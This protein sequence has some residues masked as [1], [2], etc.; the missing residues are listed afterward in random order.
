FQRLA[1]PV[2]VRVDRDDLRGAPQSGGQDG[3]QAD[4]PGAH[5]GHSVARPHLPTEHADWTPTD[6][7][8]TFIMPLAPF[9]CQPRTR[10]RMVTDTL[11]T[12]VSAYGCNTPR[13]TRRL[14]A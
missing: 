11:A 5:H 8:D 7:E 12:S 10:T 1:Q 6:F 13:C 14:R 4:G 2:L 3:G 9:Q